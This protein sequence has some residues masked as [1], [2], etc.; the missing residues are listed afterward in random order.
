MNLIVN[1]PIIHRVDGD[2]FRITFAPDCMEHQCRCRD[3]NDRPR[4][5]ACCQYGADLLIPEKLAILRRAPAIA[6]VLKEE[7]RNPDDWFDEREPGVDPGVPGGI[8]MRTATSERDIETSG[9]IFLE[10]TGERGCGLHRAALVNGFDPAEI[11]PS[12]CRLY[13][14]SWDSRWLGLSSDFNSYSC[15]HDSGP[16]VYRLMRE[17]VADMFDLRLVQELDRLE[18]QVSRYRLPVAMRAAR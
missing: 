15:A 7:R 17:V 1:H 4:N 6:S 11:K 9:C 13:P 2:I 5:D 14:L 10:H 16:S 3:E 12:A 8:V 18:S